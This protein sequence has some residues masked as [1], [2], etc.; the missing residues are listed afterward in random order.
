DS[1]MMLD[2]QEN[3]ISFNRAAERTYGYLEAEALGLPLD[4]LVPESER[5]ARQQLVRELLRG[6]H[7][8]S[9]ALEATAMHK[10]GTV[11]PVDISFSE[12]MLGDRHYLVQISRDST[13]RRKR[14]TRLRAILDNASDG[15]ITIDETGSVQS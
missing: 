11:F 9:M 4:M 5:P 13:E 7:S 1:I 14:E 3:I 10:D 15:I 2:D 6:E 8:H 12:F